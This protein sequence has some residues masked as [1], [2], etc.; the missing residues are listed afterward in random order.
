[1]SKTQK[2]TAAKTFMGDATEGENGLVKK[3]NVL[4]VT[5]ERAAQ[6]RGLGWVA[7]DMKPAIA[8]K[9]AKAP[10]KRATK[11]AKAPALEDETADADRSPVEVKSVGGGWYEVL[12]AG[13][14]VEKVQGEDAAETAAEHA[15]NARTPS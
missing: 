14:V 2:V 5:P 3:G 10:K 1:M 4:E 8:T 6:L 12:V 15:R 7:K 9:E 11:E 13:V